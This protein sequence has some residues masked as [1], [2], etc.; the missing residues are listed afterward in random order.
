MIVYLDLDGVL[1]D[2]YGYV[3]SYYGCSYKDL[4]LDD[5]RDLHDNYNL[6]EVLP[7]TK[8]VDTLIAKVVQL[9]GSYSILSTALK[10]REIEV[11]MA[12][13]KWIYENLA[14]QPE[15]IEITPN[16]FNFAMVDGESNIL[17]DDHRPN[18]VR[19][20]IFGGIGIKCKEGSKKHGLKYAIKELAKIHN[21]I[22]KS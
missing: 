19:F 18:L 20:E 11:E 16:K 1:A 9:F 17:I 10:D 3:S 15:W 6:F 4:S 21:E 14:I 13:R 22:H 8:M 2:L 5:Y 7:K 12:K